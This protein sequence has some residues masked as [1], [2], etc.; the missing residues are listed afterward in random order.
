M[1]V[2]NLKMYA[3]LRGKARANTDTEKTCPINFKIKWK[4]F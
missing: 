2:L 3:I 1:I 4:D